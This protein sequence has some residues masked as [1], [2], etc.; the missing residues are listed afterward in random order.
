ME[1]YFLTFILLP[2]FPFIAMREHPLDETN[3][4]KITHYDYNII[5][6]QKAAY[7]GGFWYL[8]RKIS[9]QRRKSRSSFRR[10]SGALHYNGFRCGMNFR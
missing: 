1:Y 9:E 2:A 4:Y 7:L 5:V 6:G 10:I 3:H 8:L